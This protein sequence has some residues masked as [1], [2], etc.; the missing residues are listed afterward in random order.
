MAAAMNGIAVHGGLI[1][2]GGTFLTSFRLCPARRSGC[3][4]FMGP[5]VIYVMTHDSIGLGEDG[6]THQPVEHLA[7]LRAMPGLYVYRPA[8]PV[9][10]AECWALGTAAARRALL[11]R[12]DP[13]DRCRCCARAGIGNR[14]ARGA[15][16]LAE[17]EGSARSPCSRPAPRFR[18]RWPRARRWRRMVSTRP[19][20]RCPAGSSSSSSAEGISGRGA[21]HGAARRGRGRRA[22][23]AGIAGS[24]RAAP[25]SA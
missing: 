18:S 9:E 1:P 16:V 5:R 15:Y 20:F 21:R 13:P 23:S 25:S 12:P 6:P 24:A 2:Y 7:A 10:T 14:S 3:R 4:R 11:A 17:A 19:S 22:F 8:D